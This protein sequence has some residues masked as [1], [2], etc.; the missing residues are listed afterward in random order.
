MYDGSNIQKVELT[1]GGLIAMLDQFDVTMP[2][3]FGAKISYDGSTTYDDWLELDQIK[4]DEQYL[5]H[6]YRTASKRN[7]LNIELKN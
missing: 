4:I 1:V 2:V 5:V 7:V 3:I 6:E